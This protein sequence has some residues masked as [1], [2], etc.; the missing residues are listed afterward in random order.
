MRPG[1]GPTHATMGVMSDEPI[2]ERGR[3]TLGQLEWIKRIL[4]FLFW[5]FTEIEVRGAEH[6]PVS[7]G[8]ILTTNHLSRLDTPFVF[9]CL[10]LR[11]FTGFAG[12]NYRHNW[13]FRWILTRVDM[14]WVRRGAITP[15]TI[16]AA[17]EALR[18]D[19]WLGVAPEGTRSP[20]GALQ[21]GR[22]GAAF[23][24]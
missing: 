18:E 14:I 22:T 10:P 17:L 13:F 19:R 11:R 5:L 7:G 20:T 1:A 15:S 2:F 23:L 12:H 4:R 16:K 8:L 3:L 21:T 6:L 9:I 24:A